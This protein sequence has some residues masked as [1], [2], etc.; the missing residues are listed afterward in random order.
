MAPARTVIPVTYE[1]LMTTDK[2]FL[3]VAD[4]APALKMA[5]RTIMAQIRKDPR[6]LGFPV[7]M[8]GQ[9]VRIPTE[10]F[11]AFLRGQTTKG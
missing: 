8:A 3:T 2:L 7:I 1:E 10:G 4:I 9:S 5:H 11:R 6:A